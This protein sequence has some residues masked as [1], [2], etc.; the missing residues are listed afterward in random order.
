MQ[1]NWTCPS[2]IRRCESSCLGAVK[3]QELWFGV[4]LRGLLSS[5]H[6]HTHEGPRNQSWSTD[7]SRKNG[8]FPLCHHPPPP[9]SIPAPEAHVRH[10]HQQHW[11]FWTSCLQKGSQVLFKIILI[12][13]N[14]ENNIE[15]TAFF[16]YPEFLSFL[17]LWVWFSSSSLA[18]QYHKG[19][20]EFSSPKPAKWASRVP[21]DMPGG[22]G[23]EM[24]ILFRRNF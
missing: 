10:G 3:R 20:P 5:V 1:A 22:L 23:T 24:D 21:S 4:F 19:T 9:P 16:S 8:S 6:T 18:H 7:V 11:L 15:I 13:Q 14:S 17:D 12:I 2:H